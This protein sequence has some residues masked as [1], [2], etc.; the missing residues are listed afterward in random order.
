M[1]NAR[2]SL[3]RYHRDAIAYAEDR[4]LHNE[5]MMG[6]DHGEPR[7]YQLFIQATLATLQAKKRRN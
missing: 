6:I 4:A 1:N 5:K 7:L 2:E 3:G